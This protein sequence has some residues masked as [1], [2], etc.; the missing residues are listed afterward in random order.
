MTYMEANVKLNRKPMSRLCVV[1]IC[2]FVLSS[3]CFVEIPVLNANSI[4]HDQM[5]QL[6]LVCTIANYPFV[7][8]QNT[9][10]H[11]I[12]THASISAQ[13]SNSVVFRLKPV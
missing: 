3:L 11:L 9:I 10:F 2:L 8:F 13:A 4:D 6:I 5:Q 1:V 7:G 12:I